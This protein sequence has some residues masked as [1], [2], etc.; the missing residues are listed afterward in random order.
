MAAHLGILSPVLTPPSG[1][2][3]TRSTKKRSLQV[4][5]LTAHDGSGNTIKAVPQKLISHTFNLSG[6]GA[7]SLS[8]VSTGAITSGT[9]KITSATQ[10][11]MNTD[12]PGFDLEGV[13]FS[14][15][16]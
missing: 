7:V 14:T 8:V 2:A 11:E 9:A 13:T 16:A 5:K 12:F 6:K 15:A 3:L 4:A 1:A 10:E